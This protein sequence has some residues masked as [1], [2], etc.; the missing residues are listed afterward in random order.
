MRVA[1]VT[2]AAILSHAAL[3]QGAPDPAAGMRRVEEVLTPAPANP[4]GSARFALPY[5]VAHTDTARLHVRV[6]AERS[7]VPRE[8]WN[9]VNNRTIQLLP[10][11]SEAG[12]QHIYEMSYDAVPGP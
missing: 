3:A 7:E 6:G 9:F 1:I 2:L 4:F 5:R 11:G 12:P 8:Q 10:I